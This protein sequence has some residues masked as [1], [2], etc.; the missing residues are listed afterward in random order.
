LFQR[1]YDIQNNLRTLCKAGPVNRRRLAHLLSQ[2]SACARHQDA[3]MLRKLVL[4][5]R[6]HEQVMSLPRARATMLRSFVDLLACEKLTDDEVRALLAEIEHLITVTNDRGAGASASAACSAS[7]TAAAAAAA[8][9]SSDSAAAARHR[10][11]DR[12]NDWVSTF[13][14]DLLTTEKGI[15]ALETYMLAPGGV[16]TT[17]RPP[18]HVLGNGV[19]TLSQYAE[20]V[21]NGVHVAM[22]LA[23]YIALAMDRI[24]QFEWRSEDLSWLLHG[25]TRYVSNGIRLNSAREPDHSLVDDFAPTDKDVGADKDLQWAAHFPKIATARSSRHESAAAQTDGPAMSES[26]R[27]AIQSVADTAVDPR[28]KQIKNVVAQ[29]V[30]IAATAW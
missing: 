26:K 14:D 20:I 8:S 29:W 11:R 13:L 21:E 9:S 1:L 17:L 6:F 18:L 2:I 12:L 5:W 23:T 24:E 7:T 4:Q 3:A 10:L 15:G 25:V 22:S 19:E 28:D 30:T 16:Q 27:R